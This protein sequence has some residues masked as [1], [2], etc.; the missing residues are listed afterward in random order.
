MNTTTNYS[1]T[2]ATLLEDSMNRDAIIIYLVTEH[3]LSVNKATKVYGDYAREHGLTAAIVSY[4][5]DALQWLGDHHTKKTWTAKAVKD[6]VIDLSEEFKVA[7]STARDYCKA[8]SKQLGVDLPIT[9]PREAIF[10]WFIKHD[11][12][13]T[14]EQFTAFAVEKLGRS[15]SNANE[16]WKG[17]ELHLAIAAGK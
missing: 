1:D 9:D 12:D 14:K 13:C 11:G 15:K 7:E 8:F 6:A 5:A 4:K 3:E 2:I 17:Y 10:A 16:Y